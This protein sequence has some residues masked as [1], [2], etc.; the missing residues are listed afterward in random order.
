MEKF[1]EIVQGIM[2]LVFTTTDLPKNPKL[3]PNFEV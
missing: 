3:F 1:V 2:P